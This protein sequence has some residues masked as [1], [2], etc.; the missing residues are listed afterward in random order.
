MS[1]NVSVDRGPSASIWRL[2]SAALRGVN[3]ITF[4][5]LQEGK[6]VIDDHN[7]E[8]L[9]CFSTMVMSFV[10]RNH[11]SNLQTCHL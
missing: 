6:D 2:R 4:R 9:L 3:T 7:S 8:S 1:A 5:L 11:A 10:E